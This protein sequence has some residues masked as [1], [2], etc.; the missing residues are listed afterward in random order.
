MEIGQKLYTVEEFEAIADAPCAWTCLAVEHAA[1]AKRSPYG[2]LSKLGGAS[3]FLSYY[4]KDAQ[5]RD[6]IR[7]WAR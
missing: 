4:S 1:W 5:H 3:E 7:V 6:R 2:G